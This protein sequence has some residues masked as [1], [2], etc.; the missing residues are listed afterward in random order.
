MKKAGNASPAEHLEQ[1]S[2]GTGPLEFL[3]AGGVILL[4]LAFL[5]FMLLVSPK[6][7]QAFQDAGVEAPALTATMLAM[8]SAMRRHLIVVIVLAVAVAGVTVL[9]VGRGRGVAG[10]LVLMILFALLLMA[11]GTALFA[12]Y[13]PY[14][15]LQMLLGR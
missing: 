11:L 2:E 15:K 8:A 14:Q 5:A 6:C 7:Q 1:F 9:A 10:V 3:L 4:L 13:L 12:V